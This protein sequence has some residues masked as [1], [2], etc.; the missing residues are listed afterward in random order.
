M[1]APSRILLGLIGTGIQASRTPPMHEHEGDAQGLRVLYQTIDLERLGLGPE[2]LSEL[3]T[4]AERMG[5]AGLNITHPCKQAVIPH[6]DALSP[7]AAAL[8]A[9]N[10]VVLREGRRVGHNTDWW[11]FAESFRRNLPGAALGRVVQL[12]AGG[13]GAAV[14]HALLTLG[15]QDLAIADVDPTRAEQVAEGLCGRFGAGRARASTDLAADMAQADGLAHCTPTG[16]AAHSRRPRTGVRLR[17]AV[18]PS[19]ASCGR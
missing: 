7:D 14:A 13:A 6:L 10:T 16:M 8:G 4:A 11:G 18:S 3:L 15:V 1:S 2:A 5:F 9:V 12:G 17:S 19:R